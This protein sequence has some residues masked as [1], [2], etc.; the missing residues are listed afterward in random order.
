MKDAMRARDRARL[1][2]IRLIIAAIKQREVD[3]RVE[4]DDTQVL[5]VLEKMLKQRRESIAQ[6]ASAGREDLV[7]GEQAEVRVIQA[8]LP[9]PLTDAEL[10]A[11]IDTAIRDTG[12]AGMRDM[13]R[14]MAAVRSSAQGRADMAAVSARIKARLG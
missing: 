13:G 2:A 3:E 10:E 7:D 4:L 6:Y 11:V 14:V 1:S 9:E 12:A 8:Y 5:A